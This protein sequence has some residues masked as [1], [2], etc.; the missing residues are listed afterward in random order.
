MQKFFAFFQRLCL[1]L[2]SISFVKISSGQSLP[3]LQLKD[4]AVWGGSSSAS[5][6]SPA[7]GIFIGNKVS[8]EGSLGSNHQIDAKNNFTLTGN[9]YSG[10]R[11]SFVNAATITGNVSA[12]RKDL[13][14][15]AILVAAGTASRFNRNISANGKVE[16]KTGTGNN[17]STV[18]GQVAVPAPVNTNYIGPMPAGNLVST[19]SFSPLPQAPGPLA[20]CGIHGSKG[21]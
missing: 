9:I 4:F 18:T 16:I 19:L 21:V 15:Q 14:Y 10:N 17:L 5:I 2:L 3:N 12:E 11:I 20:A 8:V 6:F 1:V 7:Q 13:N